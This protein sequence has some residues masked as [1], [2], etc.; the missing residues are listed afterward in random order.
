[1]SV[2]ALTQGL[3]A[4]HHSTDLPDHLCSQVPCDCWEMF[5][6]D[7]EGPHKHQAAYL[8][9]TC[10]FRVMNVR[11]LLK[12]MNISA[13][14]QHG[15][16]NPLHVNTGQKIICHNYKTSTGCFMCTVYYWCLKLI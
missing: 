15:K 13:A 14:V 10:A 7:T 9:D 3:I 1:M 12:H 4:S 16:Q 8:I 2:Y 5:I 11:A 6:M